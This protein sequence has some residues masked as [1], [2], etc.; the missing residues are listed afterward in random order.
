[1]TPNTKRRMALTILRTIG[2]LALIASGIL[3]LA[4]QQTW[5]AWCPDSGLGFLIVSM[6]FFCGAGFIVGGIYYLCPSFWVAVNAV[7]DAEHFCSSPEEEKQTIRN[8]RAEI[9]SIRA[10]FLW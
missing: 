2:A 3:L 10:N 4:L 6:F 9:R 7:I 1:M 8:A 5:R